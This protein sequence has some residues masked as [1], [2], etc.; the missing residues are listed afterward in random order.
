MFIIL[1]L[2]PGKI[3][4]TTVDY[5]TIEVLARTMLWGPEIISVILGKKIS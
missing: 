4:T 2:Q 3:E 1:F 5:G